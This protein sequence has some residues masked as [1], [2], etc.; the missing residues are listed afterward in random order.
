MAKT[1][2]GYNTSNDYEK[3]CELL[4][5]NYQIPIVIYHKAFNEISFAFAKKLNN[6][7]LF[8]DG[9]SCYIRTNDKP[10]FIKECKFYNLHFIS[11]NES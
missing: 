9:R 1:L 6:G 7:Q 11:P 8:V 5:L 2:K 4:M 10:T 3:L